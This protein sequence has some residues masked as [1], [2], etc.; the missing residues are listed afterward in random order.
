MS[1]KLKIGID[2]DDVINDFFPHWVKS[3]NKKFK[4]NLDYLS[5]DDW[6]LRKIFP[7]D[8]DWKEF[9]SVI[10][11]PD[12][13]ETLEVDKLSQVVIQELQDAGAEIYFITGTYPNQVPKKY[14][15]IKK[16]FPNIPDKNILFVPAESKMNVSVNIYIEDN[17]ENLDKYC[18]PVI[19]LN[20]NYNIKYDFYVNTN[21]HRVNSWNDIRQIFVEKYA[22]LPQTSKAIDDYEKSFGSPT[23]SDSYKEPE[24]KSLLDKIMECE[25]EDDYANLLNPYFEK[26]YD[27]GYNAALGDIADYMK[28]LDKFS[29]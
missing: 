10:D 29:K 17:P 23:I 1:Q 4:T 18:V 21:I 8:E 12:F 2:V 20:K 9:C 27:A 26:I 13:Y 3:Y 28:K 5:V 15:W 24:E 25:T 22:L 14:N 19:L 7:D 11:D 16:Y 6:D